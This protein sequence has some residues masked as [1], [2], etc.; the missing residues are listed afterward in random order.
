MPARPHA[1]VARR[2][3]WHGDK[4]CVRADGVLLGDTNWNGV[5]N[6][7]RCK[8]GQSSNRLA[9][10]EFQFPHRREPNGSI[11][12]TDTAIV[13]QNSGYVTALAT[14]W[15]TGASRHGRQARV[16]PVVTGGIGPDGAKLPK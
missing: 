15:I 13:K 14:G 1:S 2:E 4:R 6:A 7:F 3:Q 16:A 10:H 5:V 8:P 12:A 11:N 9:R